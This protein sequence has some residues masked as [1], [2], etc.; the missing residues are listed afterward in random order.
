MS[1]RPVIDGT[2]LETRRS[3]VEIGLRSGAAWDREGLRALTA[4]LQ[5]AWFP[6]PLSGYVGIAL[7]GSGLAVRETER[8]PISGRN[9]EVSAV[10]RVFPIQGVALLRLPLLGG[11]LV[12]GAGGGSAYGVVRTAAR[13]Q[14]TAEVSGWATS[15]TALLGYGHRAGGGSLFAEVRGQQV[16]TIAEQRVPGALELVSVSLGYRF[17]L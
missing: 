11:S 9:I 15:L 8:V 12:A 7:D 17:E 1:T 6:P 4:G 5:V 10:A 14:P 2:R 13:T 16:E 3:E